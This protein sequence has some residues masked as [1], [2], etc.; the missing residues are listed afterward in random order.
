MCV[1]VGQ[2]Q[3][4]ALCQ[5]L[6]ALTARLCFAGLGTGGHYG[7][8]R[9]TEVSTA[10]NWKDLQPA[11]ALL[12]RTSDGSHVRLFLGFAEGDAI[13]FRTI[14]SAISCGGVCERT[15]NPSQLR[16]YQP[17]RYRY[18]AGVS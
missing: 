10:V 4:T 1:P 3:P 7:T 16:R 11:D 13:A 2:D 8:G 5:R 6:R 18:L 9:L 14:E 12:K 17:I 15:Y